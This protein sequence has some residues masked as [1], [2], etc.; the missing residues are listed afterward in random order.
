MNKIKLEH[1]QTNSWQHLSEKFCPLPFCK[2]D[3]NSFG[4][5]FPERSVSTALNIRSTSGEI[6]GIPVEYSER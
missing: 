3:C 1:L 2:A 5:I 4:V 6:P